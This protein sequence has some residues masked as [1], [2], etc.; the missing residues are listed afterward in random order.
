MNS[1][2]KI[3]LERVRLGLMM[4]GWAILG[5]GVSNAQGTL[6][7][8]SKSFNTMVAT[9]TIKVLHINA[10]KA[11]IELIAW[12]RAEISVAMELSARHPD[13]AT[14]TKDLG[15]LQYLADRSGKDYYLRNYILLKE[16]ENKPVSNLK[17]RYTIYL[18]ATC[19]VDLK[20]TFGTIMMKGLTNNLQLKA[21]F[22][23][24]SLSNLKGK[25]ALG[26]SFGELKTN[27]VTGTFTFT[28]DHTNLRLEGI[29][30]SIKMNATYGT[31]EIL[32]SAGLTSL[33]ILSKK[34][35]VTLMTRNWQM[36]DY[37]INSAYTNMQL[38][39]GFKWKRNTEDF[40]DAFFS[41]KNQLASVQ[42]NAE[43]GNVTIK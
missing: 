22:C 27:E 43:F 25:G 7:V 8:A 14:A 37:T 13:K 28:S 4:L 3:V 21:D 34:A 40:K 11:D 6:H 5:N 41:P 29:G 26:T 23:T 20:N 18:P 38:P 42:I 24:T 17:T 32:P 2:G 10:E 19:S 30:G 16:G 12:D 35:V 9:P 1:K 15:K 33:S 31:V 39:S 36:F